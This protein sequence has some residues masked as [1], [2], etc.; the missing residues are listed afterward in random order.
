MGNDVSKFV[1]SPKLTVARLFAADCALK[2]MSSQE[3][4]NLVVVVEP[5]LCVGRRR[6]ILF[7]SSF[8]SK[9]EGTISCVVSRLRVD[10]LWVV[11]TNASETDAPR[12]ST[13]RKL[14]NENLLVVE[15]KF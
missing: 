7:L 4:C 11:G 8:R 1:G 5:I 6:G 13:M 15:F 9:T 10:T 2:T 3:N 14:R 12:S